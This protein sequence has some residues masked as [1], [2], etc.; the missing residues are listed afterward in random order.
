[1]HL[2]AIKSINCDWIAATYKCQIDHAIL[3]RS[4]R[5][6]LFNAGFNTVDSPQDNVR[7]DFDGRYDRVL[8]IIFALRFAVRGNRCNVENC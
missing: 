5:Y 7:H 4:S 6:L 2:H 3:R 8:L 1:M